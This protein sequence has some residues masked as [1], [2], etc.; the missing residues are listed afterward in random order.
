MR[1]RLLHNDRK[2]FTNPQAEAIFE[3]YNKLV[4][5]FNVPEGKHISIMFRVG[6]G[7]PPTAQSSRFPLGKVVG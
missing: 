6:R 4:R 7:K 5:I 3:A 1:L 2:A